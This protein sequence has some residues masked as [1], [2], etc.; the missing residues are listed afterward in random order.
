MNAIHDK[1]RELL[2]GHCRVCPV[3]NGKACVGEVPGMGSAGTGASFAANLSALAAWRLNLRVLHDVTAPDTRI[4]LLGKKLS[5]PVLAAPIGGVSFNMGGRLTEGEYLSAVLEGCKSRGTLGCT[6]DGVPDFIHETGFAVIQRLGGAGIPF[7]KP[8]ESDELTNKLLRAVECG[9]RIVGIDVD[10]VGLVTLRKMGRPV[11]PRSAA[12]MRELIE[13]TPAKFILKGVMT[14]DEAR[15]A[16]DIGAGAIVVSNHGGR[17]LDH[18]PGAAEVLPEIAQAVKGLITIIA[19]GGIRSGVD[20]L[21]MLAL[22]ADAVLIGR[23]F[24]RAAMGGL[25]E[26]VEIYLD[27]LRLELEQAMVLTGCRR[28]SAVDRSILC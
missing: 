9:A 6:G 23:P 2:A 7:I 1:A 18:C 11:A 17:V 28:A 3:C 19:D 24:V 26:G 27:T 15:L 10:A 22:G 16:V 12:V 14:V 4:N 13:Q 8:W 20:V 25:K 21:K 5:L